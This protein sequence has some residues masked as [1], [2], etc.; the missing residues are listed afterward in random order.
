MRSASVTILFTLIAHA[1]AKESRDTMVNQLC[2]RQL[3]AWSDRHNEDLQNT[4]INQLCDRELRAFSDRHSKELENTVLGKTGHLTKPNIPSA[5]LSKGAPS[6]MKPPHSSKSTPLS[7]KFGLGSGSGLATSRGAVAPKGV[8][9]KDLKFTYTP[10]D[11]PHE[12]I[13]V[14]DVAQMVQDGWVLIDVRQPEQVAR[15]EVQGAE[16]VP[17]YVL[18]NDFS[19][20]GLYQ[21]AAAFGLGGW[22]MGGRPMKE[23]PDFVPQALQKINKNA[24]GVI[25]FCQSGLRSEQAL[26]ELYLAGYQGKLALIKGGLEHVKPGDLPCVDDEYCDLAMAGSGNLAGML[27]W[28]AI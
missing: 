26:K 6:L 10:V 12:E 15:G 14:S 20:L 11:F 3:R 21:E 25:L 19:P 8:F 13:K 27:H 18:K 23:N 22:W 5:V 4:M 17:L 2:A 28:K 1:D 24:P 9:D 7:P 16:E